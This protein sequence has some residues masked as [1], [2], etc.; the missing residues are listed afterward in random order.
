M[1]TASRLL[2]ALSGPGAELTQ[3]L[4]GLQSERDKLASTSALAQQKLT[5]EML[6]SSFKEAADH[7]NTLLGHDNA[8]QAEFQPLLDKAFGNYLN[9]KQTRDSFFGVKPTPQ[10]TAFEL[11]N[12]EMMTFPEDKRGACLVSCSVA[13]W[14]FPWPIMLMPSA[15]FF[16]ASPEVVY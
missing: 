2:A 1:S 8:G 16:Q 4:L 3:G 6:T 14:V 11:V 13:G 7:Y 9:A 12:H 5:A 15:D 10:M